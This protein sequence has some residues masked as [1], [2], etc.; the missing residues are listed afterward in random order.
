M[1][2]K[3]THVWRPSCARTVTVDGFVA[4]PRGSSPSSPPLVW[5]AKDPADVLDYQFDISPAVAG[6]EGDQIA[7]LDIAINPGAPGDL[8]LTS[9]TADG[10]KAIAWFSLGAPGTTYTVTISITTVNGR[11][12]QRDVLL[13]VTAFSNPAAPV[14]ALQTG[15]GFALT[16]QS[17]NPILTQ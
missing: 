17:G 1:P 5:P 7:S 3:A 10:L 11:A 15:G 14:D 16:D 8:A 13:P 4:V 9:S 2:T 12:L 6:N